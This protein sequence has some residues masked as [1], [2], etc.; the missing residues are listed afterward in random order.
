MKI[1]VVLDEE[2]SIGKVV[3]VAA[4][5]VAYGLT[6]KI[7]HPLVLVCGEKPVFGSSFVSHIVSL[8][9]GF[10]S[11]DFIADPRTSKHSQYLEAPPYVLPLGKKDVLADFDLV[12]DCCLF[13][14]VDGAFGIFDNIREF[15]LQ[16][17]SEVHKQRGLF[18]EILEA[19]LEKM[20][21]LLVKAEADL[22]K[23]IQE[24]QPTDEPSVYQMFEELDLGLDADFEAFQGAM[25]RALKDLFAGKKTSPWNNYLASCLVSGMLTRL[26]E[27]SEVLE[28]EKAES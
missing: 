27:L 24:D 10:E 20:K 15:E 14:S 21:P 4:S 17:F 1:C 23:P 3:Y 22:D 25:R 12:F 26:P 7:H 5:L 18:H 6:G 16:F 28:H 11:E 9:E 2:S 13:S 19:L 8:F